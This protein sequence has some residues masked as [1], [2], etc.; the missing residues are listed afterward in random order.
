MN[1]I[2][3][4]L[5]FAKSHEWV[6]L[7]ADGA[8]TVGI[9]DYAQQS[10]GDITFTQLPKVGERLTAG[11]VFGFIE[12]V[13]AAS[14]LY[15]PVDGVVMAINEALNSAPETVNQAPYGTGWILRVR[16]GVPLAGLLSPPEYARHPG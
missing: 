10:L 13:K 7:E 9:S 1:F 5:L 11:A 14:D 4:G 8:M 16:V 6:R 12:S 2:P 15:A 3:D